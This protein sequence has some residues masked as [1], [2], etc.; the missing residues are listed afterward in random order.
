MQCHRFGIPKPV[1][2]HPVLDTDGRLIGVSDFCWEDHRHF[3]EFDGRIKYERFLRPGESPADTVF[4]EKRREDDMQVRSVWDEPVHLGD[5][6]P[7]NARQ[8]MAELAH[9]LEQSQR[10]YARPQHVI[11][12]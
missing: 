6:M 2:Q 4:R 8:S 10:L 7:S 12:S 9:A 3:G 11:A 5:L 1:L